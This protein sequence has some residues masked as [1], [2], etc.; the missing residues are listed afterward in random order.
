MKP[1]GTADNPNVY[2]HMPHA[3]MVAIWQDGNTIFVRY[4]EGRYSKVKQNWRD[5]LADIL[6]CMK[7]ILLSPYLV[8]K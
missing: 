7:V 8:I 5:Y 3:P 1:L 2:F 4:S 6:F